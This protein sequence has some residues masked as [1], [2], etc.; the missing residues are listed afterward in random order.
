MGRDEIVKQL[1]YGSSHSNAADDNLMSDAA[2][3]IE[4]GV[5]EQFPHHEASLHLTHNQHKAYYWTVE[6][7]ILQ[8]EHGYDDFITEEQKAKAIETNEVWTL[9]WYPDTPVSFCIVAAADLS[10]LL[11]WVKE[12]N[13]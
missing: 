10:E 4:H 5:A 3:L 8:G 11:A 12:N 13:T 7:A 6:E 2:D 1:R 9:Q